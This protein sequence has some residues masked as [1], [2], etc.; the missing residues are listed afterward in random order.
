MHI[1]YVTWERRTSAWI[2]M[3]KDVSTFITFCVI[4]FK[5]GLRTTE[6]SRLATFSGLIT[7]LS[8][9]ADYSQ[10][11]SHAMIYDSSLESNCYCDHYKYDHYVRI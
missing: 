7:D 11:N 6:N 2:E 9:F 3:L 1:M 4:F 10:S 5:A 8:Y